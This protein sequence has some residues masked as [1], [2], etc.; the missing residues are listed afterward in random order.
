MK[1]FFYVRKD[2]IT[3]AIS[4]FIIEGEHIS[5]GGYS[6]ERSTKKPY[7]RPFKTLK[8]QSGEEQLLVF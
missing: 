3:D 2:K 6:Y 8:S 7:G 4:E 1:T 5:F